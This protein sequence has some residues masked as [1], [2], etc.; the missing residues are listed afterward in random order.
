[1]ENAESQLFIGLNSGT[2]MDGIDA[3]LVDFSGASPQQI[4]SLQHPYPEQL[5]SR[6]LKI[7]EPQAQTTL[8]EFAQLDA[9]V[10]QEFANTA[11]ALIK[12]ANCTSPIAAIGSHGQTIAHFPEQQPGSTLQIGDP[13]L[14]A[15]ITGLVTVGDI[16][17]RD[18]AAG[19]QGAPL[20]PAY[21]LAYLQ[22]ESEDRVVANIGGIANITLLPNSNSN[23]K[24]KGYDTGPGNALM[25]RWIEKHLKQ[26]Y[27]KQGH[28]AA[29]GKLQ[30]ILLKQMLCDPYFNKPAPKSTGTDYFSSKWIDKQLDEYHINMDA[31]DVQAT[32]CHLTAASLADAVRASSKHCQRLILCGGGTHNDTLVT[33]LK[34]YLDDIIVESSAKHGIDPDW[35]EAQAFAWFAKQR[36]T[37][38]PSNIPEVTG[39]H[40]N[41]VL[42]A[43]YPGNI[44]W[45]AVRE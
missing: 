31:A 12:A 5:K 17:R 8:S 27:D 44:P 9:E 42:G 1:M 14:I 15:E 20:A 30:P 33:L 2:S 36:L 19:G 41:V 28:W 40:K 22:N 21:H 39:A 34:R 45:E 38:T 23:E 24:V 7:S 25:D 10:G 35:M 18:L 29:S 11:L 3:V 26:A 32:L 37:M 16:R 6:L 43:S 13:N 4:H